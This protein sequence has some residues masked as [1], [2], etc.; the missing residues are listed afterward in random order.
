[1]HREDPYNHVRRRALERHGLD[2]TPFEWAAMN[3]AVRLEDPRPA[4]PP[5]PRRV[6]PR[7]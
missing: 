4:R 6:A 2:V 7:G 3:R 1:M 5:E